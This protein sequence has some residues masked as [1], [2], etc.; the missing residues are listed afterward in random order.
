MFLKKLFLA[1]AS[2][3]MLALAYTL[4]ASRAESQVATEVVA[5]G[6]ANGT[7]CIS[8]VMADAQGGVYT[9]CGD[10]SWHLVATLP[11]PVADIWTPYTMNPHVYVVLKNGDVYHAIAGQW[12]FTL[13]TSAPTVTA[14]RS[15]GSLKT[16]VR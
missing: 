14:R 11:G 5:L 3:L 4:T 15:W 1:S 16:Q 13:V 9:D 12:I 7:S 10:S 6:G 8:L 2:L